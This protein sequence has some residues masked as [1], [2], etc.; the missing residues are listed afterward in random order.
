MGT[1]TQ[2]FLI[3]KQHRRKKN[4]ISGIQNSQGQ[5]VK[6][7]EEVVEV[8]STYFDNLF[9]IG[10]ADQMEECLNAASNKVTDDM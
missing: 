4:H 5:R 10:V 6:D 2:S 8:A 3:L 1:G 9:S 7:L